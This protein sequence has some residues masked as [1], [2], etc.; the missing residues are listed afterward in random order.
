MAL[1]T[2]LLPVIPTRGFIIFPGTVFHFDVARKKSIAAIEKAISD[3][4][5]IFLCGQKNE[6]IEDPLSD[7]IYEFGTVAKIK[8]M[9]RIPH[10]GVRV[11][12]EGVSRGKTTAFL[13]TDEMY[14]AEVTYKKSSTST[15]SSEEYSAFLHQIHLLI[16][17]YL[18]FN[19]KLTSESFLKDMPEDDPSAMCD[20]V[21]EHIVRDVRD[22][23]A[24]LSI[25]NVKK[26]LIKLLE[27][28]SRDLKVMDIESV[29]SARVKEQMEEHNH[30]YY[31]REQL[32][33]IRT[34]LGEFGDEETTEL[35]NM[36]DSIALPDD[37]FDKAM[38]ELRNLEKLPPTSPESAISR[39]Y[40]EVITKYPWDRKSEVSD[41]IAESKQ[42]LN[43]SHYGMEKVKERIAEQLAV[44]IRTQKPCGSILCLLGAPGVGKTSIGKAIAEATGRKY[45][46]IS[47]G[48]M[49]DEAE[50]RGHRKTYV[51]AMPGRIVNALIQA[52]VSNPVILLDE[53]D[54]IGSD[55]KGDPASALLEILDGEQ[56][57][58]FR[59]NF[60]EVGVDLS[61][62]LFICTANTLDTVPA[63]LIDRLEVIELSSY[64]DDEKLSIAKEYLIPKQM[65]KHSLSKK[66][67]IIN[68]SAIKK[69]ISDYTRESGVRNLERE[70]ASICRKAVMVLEEKGQ[71]KISVNAKNI[72]E[73]SGPEKYIRDNFDDT[74]SVGVVNGLA[75]TQAGGEILQCEASVVDG[76]GKIQITGKLGDVMKESVQ[77][78]VSFV[79]SVAHNYN[80]DKDF[81]EKK[82]IHIHFPEGAVPKDGPSAGI[83]IA[84]AVL[85][86]LNS[87]PVR[88]TVAM[89]GEISLRGRVLP[90]G[91]LREKALAAYRL[92]IKEIIIPQANKKDLNDIPAGILSQLNV[93][94]VSD[95]N[96]VFMLSFATHGAKNNDIM[97]KS[98]CIERKSDY[99][100]SQC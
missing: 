16:S 30:D 6:V 74:D 87:I 95:C 38:R 43:D 49:H 73:F 76:N 83:T 27:T 57:V 50:L 66:E 64:T 5:H 40:L 51:G 75:W 2:K 31:L 99:E 69:L 19:P 33:A 81:Y 94:T 21:A 9:I 18:E 78:A 3:D 72:T 23:Q 37:V 10:G 96:E 20:T 61:E 44:I 13:I 55:Y 15:L 89:T 92:G 60:L 28:L 67:L 32:K 58:S 22:K 82:D 56:N 71:A 98:H 65:K 91:G 79:R 80:I 8:Q 90:I 68:D 86:A 39:H 45:V 46:R 29:I 1:K 12:V 17:E 59:D 11:L 52:G 14:S 84:T 53:I 100:Y 48:G 34:E 24:L 54:K 97:L 7:D 42:I 63:P 93:H 41:N 77:T 85:S 62:V 26:R 70:I 25:T 47:L 36:I 88:K 35:R 4:G